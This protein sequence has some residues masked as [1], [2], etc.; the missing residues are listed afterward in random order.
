[1]RILQIFLVTKVRL[2]NLEILSGSRGNELFYLGGRT[3]EMGLSCQ[4]QR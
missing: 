1:M 3:D 2:K 4:K